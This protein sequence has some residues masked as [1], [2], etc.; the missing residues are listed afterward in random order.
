MAL[1]FFRRRPATF[2]TIAKTNDRNHVAELA[3]RF[4]NIHAE[5]ETAAIASMASPDDKQLA[6]T[7]RSR[8]A[9]LEEARYD[10]LLARRGEL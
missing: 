6:S 7:A 10:Y 8:E 9:M 5:W 1:S 3:T 4:C 2:L